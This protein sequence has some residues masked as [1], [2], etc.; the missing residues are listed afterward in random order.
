MTLEEI[1]SE[2]SDALPYSV[3][4]NGNGL[5]NIG[6]PPGNNAIGSGLGPL[7]RSGRYFSEV[8]D[9]TDFGI[10]LSREFGTGVN[11]KYAGRA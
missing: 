11:L 4:P 7:L 9:S 10:F 3:I 5:T 1:I 6:I 8:G 2:F